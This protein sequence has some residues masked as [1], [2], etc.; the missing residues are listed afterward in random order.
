MSALALASAM[1]ISAS[2]AEKT[3]T[4]PDEDHSGDLT[5]KTESWGVSGSDKTSEW[6]DAIAKQLGF[7][8]TTLE[9]KEAFVD[10]LKTVKSIEFDVECTA[11]A[12]EGGWSAQ[13]YIQ[14]RV[15]GWAWYNDTREGDAQT[16][17]VE[18]TAAGS[19]HIKWDV[20]FSALEYEYPET[21][22]QNVPSI[23]AQVK[24]QGLTDGDMTG[25]LTSTVKNIVI[26]YDD[27]SA[28]PTDTPTD[29]PI[30]DGMLFK[31]QI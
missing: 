10:W 27:G 11:F 20:D 21:V 29:T 28:A 22:D 30:K 12:P 7:D 9:G 6:S 16:G 24:A 18:N 5:T 15:S 3:V 19:A 8:F 17:Y 1:A 4:L 2:A 14:N 31:I 26:T 13:A 25:S 23:G